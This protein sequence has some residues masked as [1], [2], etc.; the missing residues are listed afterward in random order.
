MGSADDER[1]VIHGLE[2]MAGTKCNNLTTWD[3]YDQFRLQTFLWH[4]ISIVFILSELLLW[5]IFP[6]H[7]SHN[8]KRDIL[9]L[10]SDTV[11]RISAWKAGIHDIQKYIIRHTA[12]KMRHRISALS[13]YTSLPLTPL[14]SLSIKFPPLYN[15]IS[16]LD[17][18]QYK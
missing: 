8:I 1:D 11:V 17:F 12:S 5:P 7:I 2:Q 15:N 14:L 9:R 3:F 16:Q 18:N 4:P 10:M 13:L 6:C